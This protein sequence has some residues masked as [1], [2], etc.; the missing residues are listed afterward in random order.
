[1]VLFLLCV[2]SVA[3]AQRFD[4]VSFTPLIGNGSND[5][6]G[7]LAVEQD[8]EG[9]LYTTTTFLGSIL[10]GDDTLHQ[11]G[12]GWNVQNILI[13]KWNQQGEVLNYVQLA[14]D[15]ALSS[16]VY[17]LEFDAVNNHVIISLATQGSPLTIVDQD[18][19]ISLAYSAILRFNSELE[20][21]SKA[22]RSASYF[23]PIESHDGFLYDLS[24]YNST[25][26]KMDV[27]NNVIWS[28]PPNTTWAGC[29]MYD[30][31]ITTDGLIYFVG[32]YVASWFHTEVGYDDVN[33]L[34]PNFQTYELIFKM[35]VDGDVL[36]GEAITPSINQGYRIATDS[37]GNLYTS[38]GYAGSGFDLGSF[39]VGPS[40]GGSDAFIM[41]LNS[42]FELQWLTE[43][44][45]TGGN[46]GIGDLNVHPSGELMVI[47]LYGGNATI[48]GYGLDFS[49]YGTGFLV[50]FE[51][52]TGAINFADN[53]GS[54]GAGTGRPYDFEIIGNKYFIS[55]LSYGSSSIGPTWTARY[56]CFTETFTT[57]YLA[58]FNDIQYSHEVTVSY[59]SQ[60]INAVSN[61]DSP[62]FQWY[63][64]DQAIEGSTTSSHLPTVNGTYSVVATDQ[65]QCKAEADFVYVGGNCIAAEYLFNNNADDN[66][67][68][69]LHGVVSGGVEATI[70]R[71]GEENEAFRFNGVDA[72]IVLPTDFDFENKS[73][74]IWINAENITTEPQVIFDNDHSGLE[75]GQTELSVQLVNGQK[76][77]NI[78]MG[79]N[80]HVEEVEENQW[81]HIGIVR[82]ELEIL[83]Y[84]NGCVAASFENT[85][86]D[87]SADGMTNVA[88]GCD[89]FH[90]AKFFQGKIDDLRIY[91]CALESSEMNSLADGAFCCQSTTS[92]DV[93]TGCNSYTWIDGIT[94]TEDNSIAVYTIENNAGC[95]SLIT[96][97]LTITQVSNEVDYDIPGLPNSIGVALQ[98]NATYQWIN[99]AD[100][101]EVPGAQEQSFDSQLLQDGTEFAVIVSIGEC[102]V[103]SDCLVLPY[104]G[105]RENDMI[106][107]IGVF[108]NPTSDYLKIDMKGT[109]DTYQYR[110]YNM[111]G[112]LVGESNRWPS[113]NLID[114]STLPDGQ[115]SLIIEMGDVKRFASF[116]VQR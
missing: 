116:V 80:S 58:C 17:D 94:Y 75:F 54:L 60:L 86:N 99:C 96:L 1:M 89:R 29:S 30:M 108:P 21:I 102:S 88:L 57:Q 72:K 67:G 13:I 2:S 22:D 3:N 39:S 83:F 42:D 59:D 37:E 71:F 9:N 68:N 36:D 63:L 23:I 34:P 33:V 47:G 106:T 76:Q 52:A 10:V 40:V 19:S 56:G 6:S 11:Q 64:N 77:L 107:T 81:Y 4:W 65:Y 20:F 109:S 92:I 95:D 49:Q 110:I 51:N 111:T 15:F 112:Q 70:N 100:G 74:S 41:K 43:L 24:G 16:A 48:S 7:G 98:E 31:T 5:G 26:T 114:L 18:T 55:G 91:D 90:N 69:G 73:W 14:Q 50:Q 45:H 115:Y 44:H 87:H 85:I 82:S 61:G 78:L 101:S 104:T 25:I 46:M 84:F 97:N 53:F 35:N 32:E 62:T 103:T 28:I 38:V 113:T 12:P 66:S 8:N 105:V 79:L 27:D 93:Q